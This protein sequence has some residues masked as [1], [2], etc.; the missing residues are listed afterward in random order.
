MNTV[1]CHMPP[2]DSYTASDAAQDDWED[3]RDRALSRCRTLEDVQD[4]TNEGAVWVG[5]V[6]G[7]DAYYL[8]GGVSIWVCSDCGQI[9]EAH[10]DGCEHCGF[11]THNELDDAASTQNG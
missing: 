3:R 10:M 11:G 1:A 7:I 4:A 2:R 8:V 6:N 5:Q 9:V